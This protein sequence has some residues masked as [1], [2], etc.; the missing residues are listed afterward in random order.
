[1]KTVVAGRRFLAFLIA[2]V[3]FAVACGGS[4][5]GKSDG[6]PE[7]VSQ[8]EKAKAAGCSWV[9]QANCDDDCLTED[10]KLESTGCRGTY[11]DTLSCSADLEDI[12]EFLTGCR[13]QL[14]AYADCTLEY[15]KDHDAA[16]CP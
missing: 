2:V 7:C 9:T 13:T 3:T 12:C 16:F 10:A 14:R 4:S 8:C 5:T 15:C 11:D 6:G 1:L